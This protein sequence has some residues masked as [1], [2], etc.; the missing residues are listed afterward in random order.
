MDTVNT[1]KKLSMTRDAIRKRINRDNARFA[2]SS[3][4][5]QRVIIA[6]DV[7]AWLDTKKLQAKAGSY[8]ESWSISGLKD[9]LYDRFIKYDREGNR[10]GG[11]EADAALQAK[12]ES[13]EVQDIVLKDDF[14]C[15]ACALGGMFAC[16]V[17]RAD[18]LT[19]AAYNVSR[20]N[21]TGY[22]GEFFS[23]TQLDLI[24]T[25]FECSAYG[26]CREEPED[27]DSGPTDEGQRAIDFG[28]EHTAVFDDEGMFKSSGDEDRMRAIM[29][30][31]IANG[32]E[33]RP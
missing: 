25:A 2:A 17:G 15:K 18:K 5:V 11:D 8:F 7:I 9:K 1:D 12:L 21:L 6:K 16:A 4:A 28:E 20:S 3:P 24:E 10:L 13:T 31:I 19:L 32:G 26:S 33:F 23:Q 30:N 22:L 29:G 14:A 27:S